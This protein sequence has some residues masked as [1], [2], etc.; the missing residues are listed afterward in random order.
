MWEEEEVVNLILYQ[1]SDLKVEE[2]LFGGSS[3]SFQSR[4][5]EMDENCT[6]IDMNFMGAFSQNK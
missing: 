3:T 1:A 5:I 4:N 2:Q 6:M